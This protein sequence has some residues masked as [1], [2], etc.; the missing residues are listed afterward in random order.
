VEDALWRELIRRIND[1]I[2]GIIRGQRILDEINSNL[3]ERDL[4]PLEEDFIDSDAFGGDPGQPRVVQVDGVEILV[5]KLHRRGLRQSDVMGADLLYEIADRKFVLVQYKTPDKQGLVG[6]D[7]DQLDRLMQSC[8]AQCSSDH[9]FT[10][11]RCGA[12]VAVRSRTESLYLPACEAARVFGDAASRKVDRF[13]NGISSEV[14][15][16]LF[17]RCWTGARTAPSEFAYLAWRALAGDRL[18]VSVLQRGS[19]GRW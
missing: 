5:R 1:D 2:A 14:F 18:L 16:Q 12:W 4:R 15:Q 10:W 6:K 13:S 9:P 8:A 7:D 3:A 19:F 17:A 11:S